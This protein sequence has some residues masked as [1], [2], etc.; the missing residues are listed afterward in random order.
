MFGISEESIMSAPS[1]GSAMIITVIEDIA[2]SLLLIS[3][4][5]PLL[6]TSF[7]HCKFPSPDHLPTALVSNVFP[8]AS[9]HGRDGP[10]TVEDK[11]WSSPL[12][13]GF[14][15]AGQ[16]LGYEIVDPNGPEQIGEWRKILQLWWGEETKKWGE[17]G[18]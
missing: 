10:L 16:Q 4:I 5:M 1:Q 15:K 7:P 17:G 18:W 12:L 2:N 8:A 6:A 11:R 14:L 3:S 13:T 9:Y